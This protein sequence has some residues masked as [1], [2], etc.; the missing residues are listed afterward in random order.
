MTATSPVSPGRSTA[1]L[2]RIAAKPDG[3]ARSCYWTVLTE[4]DKG[5]R[6]ERPV[7]H[8]PGTRCFPGA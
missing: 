1:P 3:F 8:R 5:R 6:G 7:S 4:S 2:Q